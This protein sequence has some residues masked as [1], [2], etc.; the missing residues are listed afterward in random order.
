MSILKLFHNSGGV[1]VPH[2]KGAA[3]I[4]TEMLPL[5]KEIVIPMVQHIGASSVPVVKKGDHVDVGTLVGKAGGFVGANIHSGVS[6]TVTKIETV[7]YT[8]PTQ[9]VHIQPDGE[10]TIDPGL[11]PPTVTDKDSLIQ[12]ITDCG[13]IGLGGAGFPTAVKLNPKN[14]DEIEV[15]I[16]NAAECEP[17]LCGD[18]REIL[19][20]IDPLMDG[21]EA[22]M[23]Y[24]KIPACVIAIEANK[25]DAI[26]LLR[27]RTADMDNVSV[28]V[29]PSTYPQGAE[30]TI[31]YSVTGK[32]LPRGALPADVG[33][34]VDNVTTVST[35]GKY[36]RTGMPL[37]S[38][39]LTVDG[40]VFDRPRNVEVIVGTPI[41][42]VL[43]FCQPKEAPAKL[44]TGGPMMGVAQMD[45][46]YP[47][48]KQNNG[49]LA[50]SARGARLPEPTPCI[51]CGRC[52]RHCPAR[53]SPVEIHDA[54]KRDDLDTV[55]AL[56]GDLC[57]GCGS[58]SYVC[59]A[60]RPLTQTT[61]LARDT[62]KARGMK[63]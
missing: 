19:E 51:R 33:V 44:I 3:A 4:P 47:I 1:H 53:L 40:D 26:A 46:S 49:L 12:A 43:E 10:Q 58:C 18:H 63:K 56:D 13:I 28:Q 17:Y 32:E 29:L 7:Y 14:L 15:F 37:V 2:H 11:A 45:P 6:G 27:E 21:I 20:C 54:F 30:K 41:A 62:L 50:F 35:I 24:L 8:R 39:R 48:T 57:F 22:V 34:I 23:K 55:L 9:V 61:T 5:P 42:D 36:I 59:P 38:K 31:I 60:R 16:I 25:P 52:I